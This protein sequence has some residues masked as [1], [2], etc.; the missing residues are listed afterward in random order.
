MFFEPGYNTLTENLFLG[1]DLSIIQRLGHTELTGK[2]GVS[3]V[4]CHMFIHLSS[5]MH[6]LSW[7]VGFGECRDES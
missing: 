7:L 6:D 1:S 4:F 3:H 2:Q 5:S